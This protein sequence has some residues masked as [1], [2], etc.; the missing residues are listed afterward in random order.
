MNSP[1][2]V[3]P[4]LLDDPELEVL[5]DVE[6]LDVEVEVEV[7][8]EVDVEPLLLV[9]L[10]LLVGIGTVIPLSLVTVTNSAWTFHEPAVVD[11]PIRT[12]LVG[13]LATAEVT[14]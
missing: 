1:E 13:W 7:E 4:P 6:L 3:L 2:L 8:V 5:V 12:V 10:E 14:S 11:K 9:E